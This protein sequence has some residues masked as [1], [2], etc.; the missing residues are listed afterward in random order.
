MNH[1]L[2]NLLIVCGSG[3][4]TG[5]TALVSKIIKVNKEKNKI[6]AIKVSPHFHAD[7]QPKNK[8]W[9]DIDCNIYLEDEIT[10]KDSSAFFQAGASPVYYLETKDYKLK[11]AFEIILKHIGDDRLIICESG[12]LGRIFKPGLLIF[13]ESSINKVQDINKITNRNTADLIIT[14]ENGKLEDELLK[15]EN[16]ITIIGNE[17]KLV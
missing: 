16:K 14:V 8:I 2:P 12:V 5:K 15:I 6:A 1:Y 11:E 9:N 7:K 13:I 3:R 10:T 4:N 17:W